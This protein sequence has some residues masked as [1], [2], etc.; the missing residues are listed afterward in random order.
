MT[1]FIYLFIYLIDDDPVFNILT[2]R[3][4]LKHLDGNVEVKKFTNPEE[5]VEAILNTSKFPDYIFLDILMPA[6]DGWELLTI[7]H[8][9]IPNL[10]TKERK[11]IY[12]VKKEK[13]ESVFFVPTETG[14]LLQF[15]A[16]KLLS[17]DFEIMSKSKSC[18]I[19]IILLQLL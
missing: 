14:I 6:L 12:S 1:P 17:V 2:E 13:K 9:E 3:V 4:I 16:C 11:E 15:K 8:E 19:M 7:L 5:A 10:E 18:Q